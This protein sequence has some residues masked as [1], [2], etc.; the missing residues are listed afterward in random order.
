V[1]YKKSASTISSIFLHFN[2]QNFMAAN[3]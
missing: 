1:H 3:I 2:V